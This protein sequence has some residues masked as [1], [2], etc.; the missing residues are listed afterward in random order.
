MHQLILAHF[1]A[2]TQKW[3]WGSGDPVRDARIASTGWSPRRA[4]A[5]PADGGYVL[6]GHWEFASGSFNCDLDLLLAP[7][8][9]PGA[10][11]RPARDAPVPPRARRGRVRDRRHL[12][13]DGPQGHREQRHPRARA[14]G[15]RAPHDRLGRGEPHARAAACAVQGAGVHDSVWHRVPTWDW[16]GWTVAPA[17][18]GAARSALEATAERLA[19][20]TNL[21]REKLGDTQA[22]QLR[23]RR[24]GRARRRGRG[25]APARHRGD[26][27]ALRRVAG[28]RPCS[29]APPGA[30]TRRSRRACCSRRSRACSTAA[31]RTGSGPATRVE[32]AYRD[33]GAGVTH[34]GC[35]WDV[36]GRVY[37]LALLGHDIAI[38]NFGFFP[39]CGREAAVTR[40]RMEIR[41]ARL[42]RPLRAPTRRRGSTS[43]RASSG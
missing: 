1:P 40:T 17:L 43:P 33:V 13:R 9:R 36:W 27:A 21:F 29:S 34:V 12:A 37:G 15:P 22:V 23:H 11:P 2:E 8:E 25:A 18:I 24:R 26:R 14:V 30:A 39:A 42:R 3:L 16:M 7:V 19:T 31:A 28:A 38:P 20:R 5:K 32:R 6:D 10:P 41:S 35:D 4:V